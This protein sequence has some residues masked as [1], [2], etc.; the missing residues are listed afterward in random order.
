MKY[1][2]FFFLFTA[3]LVFAGCANEKEAREGYILQVND[4]SVLVAQDINL[5]RYEEVKDLNQ[6]EWTKEE[7]LKLISLRYDKA[8]EYK[9]GDHILFWIDGVVAESYPEQAT[10]KEIRLK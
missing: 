4:D 2:K 1:V 5:A 8:R 6:N 10:A 3:L 7:G 9:E